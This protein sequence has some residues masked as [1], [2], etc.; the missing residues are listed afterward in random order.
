MVQQAG[1]GVA[2]HTS[3][4]ARGSVNP[5]G[6]Q[7]QK[8]KVFREATVGWGSGYKRLPCSNIL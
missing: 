1:P 3:T 8:R 2:E 7:D 5:W 4:P 6:S